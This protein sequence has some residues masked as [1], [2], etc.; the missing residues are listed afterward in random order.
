[1]LLYYH[2]FKKFMDILKFYNF[3]IIFF[4]III[5]LE[6]EETIYIFYTIVNKEINKILEAEFMKYI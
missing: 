1:M 5:R 2:F 4:K 3:Y 6:K